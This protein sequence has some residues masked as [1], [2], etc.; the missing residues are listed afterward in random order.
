MIQFRPTTA[1]AVRRVGQCVRGAAILLCLT[2][3]A[4]RADA[5]PSYDDGFGVGCVSCHDGFLSGNGPLHLQHRT[6]FD[7][8][9]CNLCHP[10][11]GGTTPVL[12]YWSGPG[13]G[14][15]CAG[16]HG[17]DYGETSPNSG[18]AKA[19]AYGLRQFH[20]N[21]GEASC[22]LAGGCHLPG[23]LGHP[24]PFPPLLGENVAPP[25][26]DAL[27]SNLTDPCASFQEDLPFDVDSVGLDNDGDGFADY[28]ADSD[29]AA[30]IT[31]TPT[32][33]PIGVQCGTA[34]AMACIAPE[35][36]SLSVD[37]KKP[38]KEKLKVKLTKLQPVVSQSQFGDPVTGSTSYAV[39]IYDAA[40][41]LKGSYTIDRAGDT[42]GD[43]SCWAAISDKGYKYGDKAGDADGI[44]K[45][46]FI[47]GEAGK[48][49]VK[50]L[51]KN[52]TGHLPLGV[53]ALMQNQT[54]ATVQV[55]SSDASCFGMGLTQVKKADGTVFKAK[56]P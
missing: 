30:P 53:A 37:E 54:S 46:K 13:G 56:G 43:K 25:Y 23:G 42:C 26:Y 49:K 51:G 47:G 34:P 17:Q 14:Y 36:G 1:K 21:H 15:G 20:V 12:T 55:L 2:M 27:F 52:T 39:C 19:T 22:G 35:K 32:P 29:C 3:W 11:G 6:L 38:G 4:P 8:A 33:I 24:N 5:Y 50:V 31:P 16:C 18:E 28:P 10:S 44:L 9:T 41:Q 45:I 40:N 48:G 7:V